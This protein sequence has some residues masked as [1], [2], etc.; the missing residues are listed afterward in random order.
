MQITNQIYLRVLT[1]LV[2]V[3]N[4][5]LVPAAWAAQPIARNAMTD[6]RQVQATA[7]AQEWTAQNIFS[8]PIKVNIE[9]VNPNSEIVSSM[10][11]A[12]F[13]HDACNIVVYVDPVH[14]TPTLPGLPALNDDEY[15][16]AFETIVYH[17][18]THCAHFARGLRYDNPLWETKYNEAMSVQMVMA[19]QL[20]NETRFVDSQMEHVADA[21]AAVR[22]RQKY[23]DST[24]V[25]AFLTK[26]FSLRE[27]WLGIASA[28][29]GRKAYVQH[30]TQ[31][32]L[33]WGMT[34]SLQEQR[35]PL[36]WFDRSVQEAS[37]T[38][39]ANAQKQVAWGGVGALVC[40]T[41]SGG[42]E[43]SSVASS[44]L[45]RIAANDITFMPPTPW[46]ALPLD[47]KAAGDNMDSNRAV[48]EQ[49]HGLLALQE[50]E[51]L[52]TF[53]TARGAQ[54]I[55][56]DKDKIGRPDGVI[57]MDLAMGSP[58]LETAAIE[59]H[60]NGCVAVNPTI[61]LP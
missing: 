15:I 35:T 32:A 8:T 52:R 21:H 51:D 5:V 44:A 19:Q 38:A 4:A 33:R 9:P 2:L 14:G 37:I 61:G 49:T 25:N 26:Y 45:A 40:A 3:L 56:M 10:H 7:I 59:R 20:Y 28:I 6:L 42:K 60:A 18:L 58:T 36:Q 30:A 27:H 47:F 34:V 43:W 22:M 39:L 55:P 17:E 29:S 23:D 53:I 11:E 12:F 1:M 48:F 16:L 24:R 31:P 46:R 41:F 54:P 57:P 13:K 50:L